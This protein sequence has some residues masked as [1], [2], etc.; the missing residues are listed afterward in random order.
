MDRTTNAI[1]RRWKLFNNLSQDELGTGRWSSCTF[2]GCSSVGRAR[3]RHGRGHE[4]ETRHPLHFGCV[5]ALRCR[6]TWCWR[7]GMCAILG[8][9]TCS[10]TPHPTGCSRLGTAE[11]DLHRPRKPEQSGT[12]RQNK[13][14]SWSSRFEG[15]NRPQR[16]GGA[17][18]RDRMERIASL[19]QWPECRLVE[20]EVSGSL[21][22]RSALDALQRGPKA[23][24][25]ARALPHE[26]PDQCRDSSVGRAAR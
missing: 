16:L 26:A 15:G 9:I 1:E 8:Q 19:T 22:A 17:G 25:A 2:C 24:G 10:E 20:P 13:E 11:V 3:P 6:A 21:N 4:F 12:R 7:C 23:E 18:T 5:L 14:P